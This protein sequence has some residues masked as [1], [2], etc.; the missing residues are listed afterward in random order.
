MILR[1]IIALPIIFFIPGYVTFI[2]F[3]VNKIKTLKLSFFETLFLQVLA[4]IVITGLIAFTLAML[5]YFSLMNLLVLLLVYSI[6]ITIKFKVKFS[7]SSFPKPK[8]TLESLVLALII[9]IGAILFFPPS[10]YVVRGNMDANA[11][12]CTGVNLAKTG[13]LIIH[14]AFQEY[15]H[16]IMENI[17]SF[18]QFT[19]VDSNFKEILPPFLHLYSTWIAMFYSIFD[20]QT[21]LYVSPLFGIFGVL[22][23]FLLSSRLFNNKIGLISAS[24]LC[25]NFAQIHWSR[26]SLPEILGQFL[27]LSGAY[28]FIMFRRSD[29][30]F[31]SVLSAVC[32]GEMLL[33]R[34]E[35]IFIIIPIIFYFGFSKYKPKSRLYLT[36]LV[37]FSL[38]ILY[39]TIQYCTVSRAYVFNLVV[40]QSYEV[41][42]V[43]PLLFN[44][45]FPQNFVR[46]INWYI[47]YLTQPTTSFLGVYIFTGVLII[48]SVF[49]L[50]L[51]K[52][53]RVKNAL[54][55]KKFTFTLRHL[56]V[57]LFIVFVIW[58]YFLRPEY[59][60][61]PPGQPLFYYRSGGFDAINLIRLTYF[62]TPLGIWLGIMALLTLFYKKSNL[63]AWFF[64]LP[65]L[66]Y[67]IIFT[68]HAPI[69]PPLPFWSR[70]FISIIIPFL[71]ILIAYAIYT[72]KINLPHGKIIIPVL[73]LYLVT[74]L[75][76]ISSPL[77]G[78]TGY[79]GAIDN[80]QNFADN[81]TEDDFIIFHHDRVGILF[82]R[83]LWF[84]FDRKA[85]MLRDLNP[86]EFEEML[87]E[88]GD[89]PGKIY[90][91]YWKEHGL[92]DKL[93]GRD[94]VE[95]IPKDK[96]TVSYPQLVYTYL[97]LNTY[98]RNMVFGLNVYEARYKK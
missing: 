38:L 57:L 35:F 10:E 77:I 53:E 25:L 81:F 78:Y 56:F 55:N 23:I 1:S 95:V 20:L 67:F 18:Q 43:I 17:Q 33:L 12:L 62:L 52:V 61:P 24:L 97:D 69:T 29:D 45:L 48:F 49:I 16:P 79:K 59:F 40:S 15:P 93:S 92:I 6:V 60:Q 41:F 80:M 89:E 28:A 26:T 14:D 90:F 87:K 54:K 2:A 76:I 47:N 27:F 96:I 5:G 19:P 73:I 7:L 91:I 30:S 74:S 86:E 21:C 72:I 22:G 88:R 46:D 83:P 4:S 13:S 31:F 71:V 85:V 34:L 94:H 50:T 70:K 64:F 3:K 65:A 37:P 75:I 42:K 98:S 9:I 58:N 63:G 8:L 39:S 51:D 68:I 66:F 36:F 82:A 84:L 11:Y 44:I 32:I